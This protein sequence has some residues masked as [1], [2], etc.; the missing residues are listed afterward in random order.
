M[1][2]TSQNREASKICVYY[3]SD[4]PK[5]TFI[6]SGT[7]VWKDFGKI[8]QEYEKRMLRAKTQRALGYRILDLYFYEFWIPANGTTRA[9]GNYFLRRGCVNPRRMNDD[10]LMVMRVESALLRNDRG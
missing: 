7:R 10:D 5:L 9:A 3:L 2:D 1:S 4:S 6:N 8:N